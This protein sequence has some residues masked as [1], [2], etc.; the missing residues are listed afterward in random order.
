LRATRL[1]RRTRLSGLVVYVDMSARAGGDG[2]GW[3]GPGVFI[4]L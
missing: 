2:G 4:G 1:S 3:M